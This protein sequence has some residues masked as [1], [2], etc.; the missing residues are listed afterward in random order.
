[1]LSNDNFSKSMKIKILK[2]SQGA[3]V[4]G[5][6]I[7]NSMTNG[8]KI[9]HGGILFS[10]ADTCMAFSC[11]SLGKKAVSIESSISHMLAVKENDELIAYPK[12]LRNT[13]S[14]AWYEVDIQNQE[15]E[16]VA[17]FKGLC[18]ISRESWEI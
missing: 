18:K 10:F 11:N 7:D 13:S 15:K 9:A 14:L 6:T 12:I 2:E 3:C 17:H 5:L 8:H 1:M 16:R 4:I